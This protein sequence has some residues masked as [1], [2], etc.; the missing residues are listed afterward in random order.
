M[1]WDV[2]HHRAARSRRS[3]GFEVFQFHFVLEGE[4]KKQKTKQELPLM[5][6]AFSRFNSKI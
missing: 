2:D 3:Q 6:C 4:K 1:H 5:T